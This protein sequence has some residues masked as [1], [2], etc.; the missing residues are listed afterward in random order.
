MIP[1]AAAPLLPLIATAALFS[2]C[3]VHE[4]REEYPP[5][6]ALPHSYRGG[7]GGASP[8][9]AWW[10]S[11]GDPE[12]NRVVEAALDENPGLEQAWARLEQAEAL[13]RR[14]GSFLYPEVT[15]NADASHSRTSFKAG[16][17]LGEIEQESSLF[18]LSIAA[19]YEVDLWGRIKSLRNAAE[20]GALASRE[21]LE[22]IA[23]TLA[24]QVA[25]TWFAIA[26][27]R[28]QLTLLA[29][30]I[31]L[32]ETFLELVELRFGLGLAAA[33]DVYQQRLQLAT[34]RSQVPLAESRLAVLTN[35]LTVLLGR[36]PGEIEVELPSSIAPLPALPD[37]GLPSDLLTRRPDVKAV[38][39]RIAAADHRLGASMADLYPA[40]RLGAGTGFQWR[41][42]EKVF[43]T[44]VYQLA[45]GLSGPIYDGGR[46]LSE[47]DRSKAVVSELLQR[48]R[49]EIVGALGEVED[50]LVLEDRQGAYL[51]DLDR[52][53]KLSR[54]TLERSGFRYGSG[55][56]DYL[57][58]LSALQALQGLQRA[59][60]TARRQKVS[61]RIQLHRALGGG[62]T[63]TLEPTAPLADS[64]LTGEIR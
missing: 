63:N 6:V 26:E 28:S 47:V 27:Q 38:H 54:A 60:I 53:L 9:D 49:E 15:G 43:D 24:S 56:S 17:A 13:A 35:R 52:Q 19:G 41:E 36:A 12:L 46:R 40:L 5:G 57:P 14:A 32:G 16:G 18:S 23:M 37:P 44:W 33:V 45:A 2:A 62:W 21:D 3:T 22:T 4:V 1:R 29:Q 34:T 61:Y 58:V 31:E 20:A 11:F 25:E 51:E 59:E 8:P 55:L 10:E 42:V 7:G 48:Y 30:Q 50:A 39:L 64:Q